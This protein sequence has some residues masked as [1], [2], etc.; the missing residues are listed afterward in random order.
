MINITEFCT[1]CRAC[2]QSCTHHAIYMAESD[3]GFLTAKITLDKCVDC[4][5]CHKICPQNKPLV[6]NFPRKVLG[7]RLKDDVLLYQSASGGAFAGIAEEW[8]K[9]GGVVFGVQY[10]SKWNAHHICVKTIDELEHVLSSKYVQAD[11]RNSYS[12]VKR[13][14]RAGIPVLYCGTGCQIGGLKAFLKKDYDN[15]LTIDLICHGV[16]SPLLFRQYIAWLENLKEAP[17]REYD[18][19]DKHFGW[20]LNYKYKYKNKIK[21]KSCIIDPYYYRFLE[22]HT[23]REC[24]YQCQYCTPK[25]IGDITIGDYWGIEKEHPSFF[26]SK[27]VSC[28]LIN[29]DKGENAW[30]KY[31]SFFYTI[32]T[33]FEQVARHNGNLLHP[34]NRDSLVRDHIYDGIHTPHWFS[35]V[36]VASFKPPLSTQIKSLV[37]LWAKILIKKFF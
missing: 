16:S 12:E 11:T 28:V 17:I 23:Y 4:G 20:G 14:I 8:I 26:S 25:R 3:E 9:S 15:L 30:K 19:R 2:E 22:G 18:F 31:N 5:L 29:S 32:E 6:K 13:Y 27:G 33:T 35:D 21:Y 37:P 24:C 36:F 7:A 10:D 1:G 34:T